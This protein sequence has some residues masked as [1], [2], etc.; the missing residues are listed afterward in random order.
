MTQPDGD[1]LA[2]RLADDDPSALEEAYRLYGA[3]CNAL[4]YRVLGDSMR[5]EDAVQEAFAALWHRRHG[6]LVRTGGIAPWLMVV[7]RNCALA[8]MRSDQRRAA[9]ELHGADSSPQSACGD[10]SEVVDAAA[11]TDELRAALAL[12]PDEQRVVVTLAYYRFLTLGQIAERTGAPLGTVKRRA[13]LALQ[14][15]GQRLRTGVS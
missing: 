1:G 6:L 14:R 7:T 4:A 2:K 9:R 12:L 10:P 8:I 3:R 5:S 15:L 11:Q 13:Q